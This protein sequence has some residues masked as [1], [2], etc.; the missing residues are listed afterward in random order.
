MFALSA[1]AFLF[2]ACDMPESSSPGSPPPYKLTRN[3]GGT[4][5]TLKID[6]GVTIIKAGEFAAVASIGSGAEKK[7]LN[8]K[9]KGKH[10]GSRQMPRF[11]PP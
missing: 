8:T 10:W 5:F 7:T 11:A 3:E 9:S 6:E 4:N 2:H 1:A